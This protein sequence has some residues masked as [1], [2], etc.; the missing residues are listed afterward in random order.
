MNANERLA[1]IV[2]RTAQDHIYNNLYYA[3]LG[4]TS[5]AGEVAG[6]VK[7]IIRND[8]NSLTNGRSE[9]ILDELSDVLWYVQAMCVC[10]DSDLDELIE[11]L[12][13]KLTDRMN[14]GTINER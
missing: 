13:F 7:K 4:L 5:E 1:L 6:E 9:R 3:A 2:K 10:I 8:K 14:H 12:D 11:H